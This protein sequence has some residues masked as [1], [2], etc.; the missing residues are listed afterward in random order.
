MSRFPVGLSVLIV[1]RQWRCYATLVWV[2]A[3]EAMNGAA[4]KKID[5]VALRPYRRDDL[6]AMVALD[7]LCFE[8]PFLFSPEGIRN[9]AEASGALALIAER[10]PGV[11]VGFA[12]GQMELEAGSR[13]G[14]C[15]TLDVA[16][17]ERRGGVGGQLLSRLEQWAGAEGAREMM[18]HVFMSNEAA[19]RFYVGR[20]YQEMRRVAGFYRRGL[21]AMECRKQI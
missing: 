6:P 5:A 17:G 12:I 11:M 13:V 14:Y 2:S 19:R 7:R 16:P 10:G 8:A 1:V 15:V 18:L 4:E 21:D 3:M 9:F 20:G